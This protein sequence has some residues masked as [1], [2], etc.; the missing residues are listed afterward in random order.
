M[1]ADRYWTDQEMRSKKRS[2][3]VLEALA[4]FAGVIG[5]YGLREAV[6]FAIDMQTAWILVCPG[7]PLAW[8]FLEASHRA[9]D[10]IEGEYE[11]RKMG[12]HDDD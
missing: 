9:R 6:G 12:L 10:D 2:V 8:A 5:G 11:R 3:H 4:V 1:R 7:I